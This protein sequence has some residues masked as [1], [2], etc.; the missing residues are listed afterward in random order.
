MAKLKEKPLSQQEW[1]IT[2]KL[3]LDAIFLNCG[4]DLA[5]KI[6]CDHLRLIDEYYENVDVDRD[7]YQNKNDTNPHQF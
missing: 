5:H 7:K 1:E 4:T 2:S 3:L 6:K